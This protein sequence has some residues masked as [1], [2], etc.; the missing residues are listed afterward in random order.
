MSH[1]P[2]PTRRYLATWTNDRR[3]P[4]LWAADGQAYA[5]S[6]LIRRIW[7]EAQWDQAPS[8][9]NDALRWLLP[10]E[11]TLADLAEALLASAGHGGDAQLDGG[12][13]D[14][15]LVWELV[16]GENLAQILTQEGGRLP[17]ARALSLAAQITDVLACIHEDP[18][19]HR[20]LKP[21]NVMITEGWKAKL[22]D[23]GVAAVFGAD[24]P[25]LTQAGQVLGTV[26][27]MAP[28]QLTDR[29]LIDP[30]TD[31]YALGCLLYEMLTGQPPFIGD[32]AQVMH[33]HR[34]RT[35]AP[36]RELRPDVTPDINDLVMSMLAKD[37]VLASLSHA[38]T[39]PQQNERPLPR[40]AEAFR[41]AR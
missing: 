40:P 14:L 29:G 16:V 19:V 20:D 6:A 25:R 37:A 13:K 24:H 5:P 39:L 28:E 11:G 8:A 17:L 9:V 34:F 23:F 21:A 2:R 26:A 31:L 3:R 38:K 10:D 1:T 35:P 36:V 30:K 7:S 33:D 4:L 22:L 12:P 15:Y 18:V 41:S 27:Y 32:H